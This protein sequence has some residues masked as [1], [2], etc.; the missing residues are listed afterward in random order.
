[1]YKSRKLCVYYFQ[2]PLVR[3]INRYPLDNSIGFASVYQLDSD[4]IGG[5]RNPPFEQP[6]PGVLFSIVTRF[7]NYNTIQYNTIQYNILYLLQ[8]TFVHQVLATTAP[9][10]NKWQGF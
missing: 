1:M 5:W 4:L 9:R 2:A 7:V 3:R 10:A 8:S 6:W